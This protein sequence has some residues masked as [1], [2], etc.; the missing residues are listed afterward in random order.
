[1][2]Q[3]VLILC[4]LWCLLFPAV[5]QAA[6]A[7]SAELPVSAPEENFLVEQEGTVYG[8]TTGLTWL[9]C[10]LGQSWNGQSC[11]GEATLLTWSQALKAADGNQFG[12]FSDWR[13][14]NKNELESIIELSCSSP[15]I[16]E[17]LFPDTPSAFFWSA[18]PYSGVSDGAWSV[19][20]A[21]G[22]LVASVKTGQNYVRLVRDR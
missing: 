14:P 9:R 10:S 18:S 20:F 3:P 17:K 13:L 1:M 21:Y 2:K 15:A 19:D 6:Q 22:A 4:S 12:G 5:V 7:C 16:N 11:Q 8:K